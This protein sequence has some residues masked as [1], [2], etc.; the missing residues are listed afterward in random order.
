[1]RSN[2]LADNKEFARSIS[3]QMKNPE[4][5]NET[6]S[7]HGDYQS[8]VMRIGPNVHRSPCPDCFKITE[9][10]RKV[11]EAIAQAAEAKAFQLKLS[12]ERIEERTG[13]A[14]IPKRF[15]NKRFDDYQI[16]CPGQQRA[17]DAC[18][19]YA[20]NFTDNL[21]AGRCLILSGKVGTG[22]THLAASIADYLINQT[23]Y[24]VVFRSLHSILQAIKNTYGED[25][26]SSEMEIFKIL[27]KPDLLIID[28]IGATKSTEFELA[29]LFALINTRYENQLPTVIITNLEA[30]ELAGSIG[31]RCVDRLRENGGRA[32]MFD[33][34]SKRKGA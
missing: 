22:K 32:L 25:S 31:D 5:T 6:C 34:A 27:T 23:E 20:H 2:H 13:A 17:L 9:A 21:E 24:S 18:K 16:D 11:D 3:E 4:H 26:T 14:M 1:M 29:T 12:R 8:T 15:L 7:E 33:W 28:E 10:Q 30:K 19:D